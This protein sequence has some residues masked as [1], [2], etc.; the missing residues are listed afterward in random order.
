M[1]EEQVKESKKGRKE[2]ENTVFIGSKP[3]KTF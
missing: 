1:A 3:F 2:D